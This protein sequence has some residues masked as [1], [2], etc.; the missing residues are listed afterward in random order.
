MIK[1]LLNPFK[2][3]QTNKLLIFGILFGILS[4]IIQLFTH[5]RMISILKIIPLKSQ[6]NISLVFLDY[7]IST[8]V[9]T[10]GLFFYGKLIYRPTRFVDILNTVLIARIV[11]IFSFLI[12]IGGWFSNYTFALVENI[13][14]PN[15]F[16]Q[17]SQNLILYSLVCFGLLLLIILFFY[18][19]FKGFALA[20]NTKKISY[21]IGVFFLIITLDSITRFITTLYAA[22]NIF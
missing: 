9:L 13:N 16:S 17:Q 12:D 18:Y 6:P 11:F 3:V 7:I 19:I 15:F 4:C 14:N 20:V 22:K 21:M 8:L 5:F 1:L 10:V 2:H